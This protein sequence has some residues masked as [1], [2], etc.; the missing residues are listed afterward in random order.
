[1]DVTSLLELEANLLEWVRHYCEKGGRLSISLDLET[2]LI[3]TGILDSVAFIE[4][5]DL[6]ES[7]TGTSILDDPALFAQVCEEL[8]FQLVSAV[9]R[10]EGDLLSSSHV[11]QR[12]RFDSTQSHRGRLR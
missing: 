4:L 8:S 7:R 2:D 12:R 5:I 1:M 11:S 3:K 9:I 6:V 10:A